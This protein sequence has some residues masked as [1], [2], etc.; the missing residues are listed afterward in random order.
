MDSSPVHSSIDLLAPPDTYLQLGQLEHVDEIPAGFQLDLPLAHADAREQK[1]RS[2]GDR[3]ALDGEKG[4]KKD[5][6]VYFRSR[7]LRG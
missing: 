2:G 1:S 4:G 7:G 5:G 3:P 6:R